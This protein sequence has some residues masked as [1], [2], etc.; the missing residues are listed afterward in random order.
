MPPAPSSTTNK[1]ASASPAPMSVPPSISR[2]AILNDPASAPTYVLILEAANKKKGS[3]QS[4]INKVGSIT[5]D[6]VKTI[7]ETKMKDLNSFKIES[8]MR[9]IAGT[10]RSMGVRV[11]G[12]FPVN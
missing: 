7:A 2:L 9:M 12:D 5:W 10:A 3:D 6:Q 8:A 1:S 11:K 4:N